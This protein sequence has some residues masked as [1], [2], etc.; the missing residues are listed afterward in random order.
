M[1]TSPD[2][3]S[4]PDT[5]RRWRSPDPMERLLVNVTG[6]LSIFVPRNSITTRT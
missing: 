6:H 4:L 5:V 2:Q 3:A 1:L